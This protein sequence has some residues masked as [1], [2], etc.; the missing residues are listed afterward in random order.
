[1]LL[2]DLSIRLRASGD[3][4]V[5]KWVHAEQKRT[6][7]MHVGGAEWGGSGTGTSR[8]AITT[9]NPAQR[10]RQY[11][12]ALS[13]RSTMANAAG[14]LHCQAVDLLTKPRGTVTERGD[15]YRTERVVVRGL[16]RCV[17]RPEQRQNRKMALHNT[18][19]SRE[20]ATIDVPARDT[21]TLMAQL[22]TLVQW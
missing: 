13:A 16:R 22:C 6:S 19:F 2:D 5:N 11:C 7:R 15:C 10:S 3:H 12:T 21:P 1:M 20:S 4:H 8:L 18:F 14:C 17:E 9:P